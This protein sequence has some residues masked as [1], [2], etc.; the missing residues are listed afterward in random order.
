[1]VIRGVLRPGL[2]CVDGPALMMPVPLGKSHEN[3][4]AGKERG[5][6]ENVLL[7]F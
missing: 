4:E 3:P 5:L 2:P 6:T 7:V 1:M